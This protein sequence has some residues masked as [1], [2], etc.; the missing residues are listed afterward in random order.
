M[1]QSVNCDLFLYADDSTLLV[2]GKCPTQ[3]ERSFNLELKSY[4]GLEN[5]HLHKT[6]CTVCIENPTSK[7]E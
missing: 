4:G 7:S 3:I 2:S 1:V 6:E 5:I